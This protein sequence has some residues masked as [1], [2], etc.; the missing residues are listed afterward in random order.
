MTVDSGVGGEVLAQMVCGIVV[1][2]FFA[3]RGIEAL[4]DVAEPDFEEIGQLGHRADG[5]ARGL[6][7]VG[8]LDGDGRADVLDRVDLGLVEQ[9]EKLARVGGT[10]RRSGAGP[11]RGACRRRGRTCP[12]RSGR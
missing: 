7:G 8:L 5:R 4:G 6:D 9:V 11:R 3:G 12:R 1:L 2:D 10:S